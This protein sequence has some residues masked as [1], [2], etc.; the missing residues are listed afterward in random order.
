MP[1][2]Q[3]DDNPIRSIGWETSDAEPEEY[4]VIQTGIEGVT[5]ID[6]AEQYLGEYSIYWL[7]VWKG[8]SLISRHNARNIDSITYFER[9]D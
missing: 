9:E 8:N 3:L 2:I 6:C 5:H 7:Q 4:S 1:K